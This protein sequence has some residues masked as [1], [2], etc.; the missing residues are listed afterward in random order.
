[1]AALLVA[2][3]GVALDSLTLSGAPVAIGTDWTTVQL[4]EALTANTGRPRLIVYIRDLAA[5]DMDREQVVTQ[6][7]NVFPHG[8][9]QAQAR[10]RDGAD[11]SLTLTG[12]SFFRGMPGLVL[13]GAGVARGTTFYSLQLRAPR[14]IENAVMIWL[15]SLGRARPD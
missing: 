8:S 10:T 9:V 5:V 13:E 6:L 4:R 3:G 11:Y 2:M 12:Y 14:P 15:D 1:V 7:P